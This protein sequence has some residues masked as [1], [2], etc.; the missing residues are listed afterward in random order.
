MH[1]LKKFLNF[2]TLIMPKLVQGFFII[3]TVISIVSAAFMSFKHLWFGLGMLLVPLLLRLLAE[4]LIIPFKQFEVLQSI[5][6]S[7]KNHE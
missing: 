3:L 7:V 4:W 2:N 5:Q 6:E 1:K